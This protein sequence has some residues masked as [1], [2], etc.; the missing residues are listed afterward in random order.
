MPGLQASGPEE[1]RAEVEES[2]RRLT[3]QASIRPHTGTARISIAPEALPLQS[4]DYDH[5]LLAIYKEFASSL[6]LGKIERAGQL[7]LKLYLLGFL[8]QGMSVK[9]R[10]GRLKLPNVGRVTS[11][12]H[13]AL[14]SQS[15]QA[16]VYGTTEEA[17]LLLKMLLLEIWR[18]VGVERSW[19]DLQPFVEATSYTT[20]TITELPQGLST[21]LS[22]GIRSFIETASAPGGYASQM[23]MR[24]RNMP[25][26]LQQVKV[27]PA[28]ERLVFEFA[29]MDPVSGRSEDC[30]ME[31]V[32]HTR[33]DQN[34][35]RVKFLSELP[36][37]VHNEMVNALVQHLSAQPHAGVE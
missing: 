19:E 31:I 20:G 27:V 29:V 14:G 13:F 1:L 10:G 35:V 21:W 16:T 6:D 23:G 9:F 36:S 17:E 12:M 25:D 28:V 8:E 18:A 3:T 15:M 26:Y 30:N 22:P 5:L 37:A 24:P 2:V 33:F 32:V 34:R 7:D 4:V 11:I